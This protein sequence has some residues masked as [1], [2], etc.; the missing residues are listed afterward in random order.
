[1]CQVT[2]ERSR[3]RDTWSKTTPSPVL[4]IWHLGPAR[5]LCRAGSLFD[6]LAEHLLH[7]GHEVVDVGLVDDLARD[8]DDAVRGN[9]GLV[10][11]ENL[12][13]QLHALIAPLEGLLDDRADDRAFLDP[14]EGDRILIEAD[15]LDLA[16]LAGFLEHLV[17]ARGVVGVE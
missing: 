13:H 16:E 15:H 3:M 1:R 17:D 12:G 7:R 5:P 9:A 10:A 11:L 14:A 6:L 2:E 4:C 8:D